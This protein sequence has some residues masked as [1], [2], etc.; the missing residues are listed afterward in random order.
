MSGFLKNNYGK[1]LLIFIGLKKMG[2]PL[3]KFYTCNH[4]EEEQINV[5]NLRY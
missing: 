2:K 4:N 5:D 1:Y 3:Y